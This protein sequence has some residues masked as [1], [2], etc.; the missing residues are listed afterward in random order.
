MST[1]TDISK[2]LILL[3]LRNNGLILTTINNIYSQTN[4]N[5][6]QRRTC[7]YI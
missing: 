7:F 3:S 1:D 4:N 2:Y 5:G 6:R